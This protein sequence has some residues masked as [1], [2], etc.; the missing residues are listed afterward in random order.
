MKIKSL[1]CFLITQLLI[2]NAFSQS[3]T[4][5]KKDVIKNIYFS[6]GHKF[7]KDLTQSKVC[8]E[9]YKIAKDSSDYI[10]FLYEFELSKNKVI[11]P[12]FFNE[13]QIFQRLNLFL[14]ENFTH[15]RWQTGKDYINLINK[16]S[17]YGTL[18]I[19]MLPMLRIVRLEVVVSDGKISEKMNSK[20]VLKKDIPDHLL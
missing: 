8:K 18:R 16:V 3:N 6:E 9:L 2:V 17:Y 20:I 19:T 15:Y 14:K 11:N 10:D 1:I 13:D 4:L 12:I 5:S 7:I